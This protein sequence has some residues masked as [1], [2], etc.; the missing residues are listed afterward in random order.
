MNQ[1]FSTIGMVDQLSWQSRTI[2]L[3]LIFDFILKALREE[4]A[5]VIT[6][7]IISAGKALMIINR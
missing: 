1:A 4:Y 3:S 7:K 2:D 6:I 5:S